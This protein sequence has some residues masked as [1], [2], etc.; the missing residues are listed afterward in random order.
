MQLDYNALNFHVD[1]MFQVL[2]LNI[3]KYMF[4]NSF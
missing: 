1:V 3:F 2:P 4:N